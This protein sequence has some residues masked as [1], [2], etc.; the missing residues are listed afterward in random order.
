M[1]KEPQIT[2]WDS[3]LP[4]ELQGLKEELAKVDTLLDDPQI[5]APY[6]ER[7]HTVMDRPTVPIETYLRLMYLKFHYQLGYETLVEEV[8]DSLQWRRFCRLPLDKNA[9]HSTTLIK[10]TKR[11]GHECTGLRSLPEPLGN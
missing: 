1:L 10:L 4:A 11:F 2:F 7:F 8:S 5:P 6:A 9:P 3:L